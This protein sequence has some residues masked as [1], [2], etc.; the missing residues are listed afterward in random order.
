MITTPGGNELD[1]FIK[2]FPN[3]SKGRFN[4]LIETGINDQVRILITD[5]NGRKIA[6]IDY[7]LINQYDFTRELDL[8]K[9][10]N[11]AYIVVFHIGSQ[12]LKRKIIIAR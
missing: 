9:N 8:T 12:S 2:I 7:G 10:L 11:G 3:P 1:P 4:F 5:I 6:A